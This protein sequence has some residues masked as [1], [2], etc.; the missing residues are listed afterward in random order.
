VLNCKQALYPLSREAEERVE[1]R[2]ALGVS[3]PGGH[4][5]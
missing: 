4:W 2:S 5:R 1:Q 3:R